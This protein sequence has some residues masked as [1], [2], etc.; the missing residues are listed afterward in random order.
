[1]D[2]GMSEGVVLW[3]IVGLVST[4]SQCVPANNSVVTHSGGTCAQCETRQ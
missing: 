2:C 3:L 4:E 1:M